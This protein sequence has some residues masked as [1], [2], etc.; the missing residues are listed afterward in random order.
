MLHSDKILQMPCTACAMVDNARCWL[1]IELYNGLWA[2]DLMPCF[3]R[4][5]CDFYKSLPCV[6]C[7]FCRDFLLSLHIHTIFWKRLPRLQVLPASLFHSCLFLSVKVNCGLV[8]VAEG[9]CCELYAGSTN[10]TD[11]LQT[12][13][14]GNSDHTTNSHLHPT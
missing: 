9:S 4:D 7:H 11:A 1:F 3:C 13:I 2:C 6:F 14:V 8:T 12:H 10:W 5:F